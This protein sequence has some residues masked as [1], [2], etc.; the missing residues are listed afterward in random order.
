MDGCFALDSFLLSTLQCFYS[1]FDCLSIIMNYLN[2]RYIQLNTDISWFTPQSLIYDPLNTR[3]PRNTSLSIITKE[4]M[5]EQWNLNSSFNDYYSSCK[6]TYCSYSSKAHKYNSI[7]VII[8][9][10]SMINGLIVALRLITPQIV[11]FIL[12]FSNQK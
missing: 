10:V 1:N 9:I 12:R 5:I 6:P 4:M 2:R 11:T 3:F 8:K 7:E